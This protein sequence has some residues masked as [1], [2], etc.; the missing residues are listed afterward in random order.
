MTNGNLDT[1][2]NGSGIF[3]R[4]PN[5]TLYKVTVANGGTLTVVAQ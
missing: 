1:Y 4:S 3:M 2:G 5:G